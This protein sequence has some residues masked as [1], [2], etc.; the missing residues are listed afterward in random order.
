[1]KQKTRRTL[2]FLRLGIQ[3]AIAL[4]LS[5]VITIVNHGVGSGFPVN[6]AKGFVVAFAIIPPALQIIPRWRAGCAGCLATARRL[7]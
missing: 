4:V 5:L 1:M 2:F 7:S 3:F 6:W